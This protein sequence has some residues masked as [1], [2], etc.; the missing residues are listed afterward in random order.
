MA[1]VEIFG[2]TQGAVYKKQFFTE[3]EYAKQLERK[4]R[5]TRRIKKLGIYPRFRQARID[6]SRTHLLIAI[7]RPDE[8]EFKKPVSN[9]K[10]SY[11][12]IDRVE[13]KVVGNRNEKQ[14]YKV[15]KIHF[16]NE[17]N[18]EIFYINFGS[19][20]SF[21]LYQASLKGLQILLAELAINEIEYDVF[22]ETYFK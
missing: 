20:H 14:Y 8:F 15:F 11:R 9:F 13:I 21:Y 4:C 17:L 10:I 3:V 5:K 2:H 18:E 6:F 22:D 19:T 16:F 12:D 7:Y 1:Q